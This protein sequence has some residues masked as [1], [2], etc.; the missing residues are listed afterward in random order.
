MRKAAQ[1]RYDETDAIYDRKSNRLL[2]KPE[3]GTKHIR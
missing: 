1:Y 3:D 2:H